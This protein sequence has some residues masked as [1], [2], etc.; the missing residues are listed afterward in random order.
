MT[1]A[2]PHRLSLAWRIAPLLARHSDWL[3]EL[4]IDAAAERLG[5]KAKIA[6]VEA[7]MSGPAFDAAVAH[8]FELAVADDRRPTNET[9]IRDLAYVALRSMGVDIADV[10]FTVF[11]SGPDGNAAEGLGP[12]VLRFGG[13]NHRCSMT[14]EA[15]QRCVEAVMAGVALPASD[16]GPAPAGGGV[17]VAP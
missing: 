3:R 16:G 2:D 11:W 6:A 12:N 17:G 1:L 5:I 15:R 9:E 14:P 7:A 10:Q 4:A 13:R 8:E